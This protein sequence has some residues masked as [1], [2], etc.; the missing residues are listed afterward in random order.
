MISSVL[1]SSSIF[2]LRYTFFVWCRMTYKVIQLFLTTFIR[3]FKLAHRGELRRVR[4]EYIFLSRLDDKTSSM[5]Y[6][7]FCHLRNIRPLYSRI[8]SKF[9]NLVFRSGLFNVTSFIASS[10]SSTPVRART[11]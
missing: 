7:P 4:N 5:E 11:G 1:S 8:N 2:K 6:F 9:S 10:G 3:F